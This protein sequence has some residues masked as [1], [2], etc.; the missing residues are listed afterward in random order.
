MKSNVFRE[1][2][3]RG[4][5]DKEL[6]IA[7]MGDLARAIVTYFRSKNP[8][9]SSIVIGRDGRTHSP[10]IKKIMIDAIIDMGMDVIDIDL[11]PT[12]TLYFSLFNSQVTSGFIITASHNPKEYTGIKI[13]FETQSVWGK[14]IQEI[15]SLFEKKEFKSADKKGSV[16]SHTMNDEYIA[17]LVD[18]FS[19]LKNMDLKVV[20]DCSNGTA[21]S[22]IPSL[23][24]AMGWKNIKLLHQ[25]VDGTFPNHEADPTK[26][27]N[28]RDVQKALKDDGFNLGIGFD[29]DCDRMSPMTRDGQLILGDKLLILFSRQVLDDHEGASIV[30]DIKASSGLVELLEKWG[31]RPIM[32]PSGHSHIKDTLRKNNALLAGELSCH[33]FFADRYFGYDDGIYAMMRLFE[34]II[35]TKKTL[36]ELLEIFPKKVSSPEYRL[37]CPEEKKDEIVDAVKSYLEK[38]KD[39]ELITI[40]GVRAQTKDG[41]GLVRASNTQPVLSLR[42]ESDTQE[43]LERIKKL[44]IYVL[45][46]YLD[47][48]SLGSLSK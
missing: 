44:F 20:I 1:Y 18:H 22:V 41:W 30:F 23:V 8:S 2:D 6:P 3:I 12:P 37:A 46:D 14:E 36:K 4:I 48:S 29:G 45:K 24:D 47:E 7:E 11:C 19:H 15:K 42:F 40:D 26:P 38:Q 10:K 27:E 33:F 32:A 28:M 21:G 5:V 16:T 17:W 34:I 25:E 43:G 39:I 35:Q 31:A 9:L 13:C